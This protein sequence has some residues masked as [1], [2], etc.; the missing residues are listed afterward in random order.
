MVLNALYIYHKDVCL[1]DKARDRTIKSINLEKKKV[2]RKYGR[3]I[4]ASYKYII[5][6]YREDFE[7]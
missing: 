6:S 5:Q 4:I 7:K 1:F 3:L 2:E